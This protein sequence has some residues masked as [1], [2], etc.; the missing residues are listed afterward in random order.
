MSASDP[1]LTSALIVLQGNEAHYGVASLRLEGTFKFLDSVSAEQLFGDTTMVMKRCF[2]GVLALSLPLI[3]NAQEF[4][5]TPQARAI[6]EASWVEIESNWSSSEAE[7]SAFERCDDSI[8]GPGD[9][10]N[11]PKLQELNQEAQLF[12][13]LSIARAGDDL[14]FVEKGHYFTSPVRIERTHQGG[15]GAAAYIGLR[16]TG[17]YREDRDWEWLDPMSR[18]GAPEYLF[19]KLTPMF[20]GELHAMIVYPVDARSGQPLLSSKTYIRCGDV[21]EALASVPAPN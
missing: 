15:N 6:L 8:L 21:S 14:I 2:F 1:K 11:K 4:D 7:D 10:L 18:E 19:L 16:R 9:L 5:I 12:G 20:S 17:K 13:E 3:S